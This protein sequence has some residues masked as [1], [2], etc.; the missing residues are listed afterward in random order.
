MI[1]QLSAKMLL[2]VYSILVL[3]FFLTNFNFIQATMYL[4][5]KCEVTGSIIFVVA[6]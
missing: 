5:K 6:M 1:S 2:V 3:S 4:V